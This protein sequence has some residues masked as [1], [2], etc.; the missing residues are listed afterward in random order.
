MKKLI[1]LFILSI[2]VCSCSD[3][4]IKE[5]NVLVGK[6]NLSR[7][8]YFNNEE[9]IP[10]NDEYVYYTFTSTNYL[11]IESNV[12]LPQEDLSFQY[13]NPKTI[14]YSFYQDNEFLM[15][16]VVRLGD[17]SNGYQLGYY[18]FKKESNMLRLYE[19]DGKVIWLKK[20]D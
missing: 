13:T 2:T 14:P 11:T 4:D 10:T 6:W 17:Q 5:E 16:K 9:Y 8:S 12:N 20:I 15:E 19:Y 18:G 3:D 7:I 1:V